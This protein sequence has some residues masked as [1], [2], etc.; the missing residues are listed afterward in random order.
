MTSN[1]IIGTLSNGIKYIYNNTPNSSSVA[2]LLLVRYGAGF[3]QKSGMA[4]LLEHLLFK[5]T[6]KRPKTKEIMAEFNSIGSEFNAYTSKNFTGYHAKSS[7]DHLEQNID[8]LSDLLVNT[9]FYREG[10]D[11]EF[12]QEK[13]IVLEELKAIKDNNMRY[14]SECLEKNIFKNE[15]GYSEKDDIDAIDGISLKDIIDT[16]KKYYVGSNIIVSINGN[17]GESVDKI[18]ELLQKYLGK[19]PKGETNKK[20]FDK[21]FLNKSFKSTQI[22]TKTNIQKSFLSIS[23]IDNGYLSRQKYYINELFRLIFCDLTSGRLFQ[24]IREKLGL[25]YSIHSSHFSYDFIGFLSIQTSTNTNNIK[26]GKLLTE[27]D[28]QI[29]EITKNGMTAKELEIAK[30]NFSSKMLLSL[31]DSMTLTEYNAYELFYHKD[32]FV[33]YTKIIDLINSF[34]L[35]EMNNYIKELFKTPRITTIITSESIDDS[36]SNCLIC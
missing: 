2:V 16:Y 25:V 27:Y 26:S 21:T 18:P 8:I 20:L 4:H 7:Y 29:Y 17:L 14:L 13:K 10:F 5:G 33:E 31:E 32:D 12:I 1:N 35:L 23:Y 36:E 19:L 11:N 34:T 30:S 6:T 24:E 28:K 3:D 15:L 22:I 9:D